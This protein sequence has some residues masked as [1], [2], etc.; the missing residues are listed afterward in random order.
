MIGQRAVRHFI[1]QFALLASSLTI[2]G[3]C[4]P[5][6][7]LAQI[8]PDQTL[9]TETTQVSPNV[10]VEDLPA[11]LIEGGAVRG[12]TLFHSFQNFNVAEF[13]RVYFAN[14]NGIET[15]LSRV[16]GRNASTILGTLGV[17]GA[18]D[19]FLLNPNGIVF[20]PNAQL[21]VAGSFL[22]STADRFVLGENQAFSAVDPNAPP[23]L[24]VN[25]TPGL[26][27]SAT[28]QGMIQNQ[29]QLQV[30]AGQTLTLLGD[31]VSHRGGLNAPQGTVEI[32]GNYVSLEDQAQV[33]TSGES[34]GGTVRIGGAFQGQGTVPTALRTY[35]GPDVQIRSD[36]I[37][38]G[39]G[40]NVTVWAN[41]ITGFYGQISAQGAELGQGGQVEVSGHQ[42]L[43]FRGTVNTA[44]VNGQMGT[45]L[46][47][48]TDI[49]IASGAGDSG[50]DGTNTF[51]GN[52]SATPGAILSTPLSAVNDTAPTTIFE[53]E[54]ETLAG[55]TNVILQ[56]TNNI[57]I[58][59]LADNALTF[60]VGNGT[61]Q[62][63]ADADQSGAGSVFVSDLNDRIVTNG[64]DFSASGASITL[65][66]INT[67]R[68]GSSGGDITLNATGSIQTRSL[69]TASQNAPGDG[70][71]GDIIFSAGTDITVSD[72]FTG[73]GNY[74]LIQTRSQNANGNGSGGDVTFNAGRDVNVSATA[75]VNGNDA[76]E[77]ELT[78]HLF[79]TSANNTGG[80]SLG[81]DIS[82]SAGRDVNVALNATV[83]AVEDD[84]TGED[85]EISSDIR[86]FNT[87]ANN[88][89]TSGNSIG[90]DITLS[91]DRQ[92][93]L[94][95]EN[96]VTTDIQG[97]T[98]DEVEIDADMTWGFRTDARGGDDG[99]TIGDVQG[100]DVQFTAGDDVNL[101][102][103][104]VAE[105]RF[106]GVEIE[107]E[108]IDI[109]P[110]IGDVGSTRALIET[111]AQN[112]TDDST[113]GNSIGGTVTFNPGG[114][115]NLTIHHDAITT[116]T[117]GSVLNTEDGFSASVEAQ[118]INTSARG[119][120]GNST[121]QDV[122]AGDIVLTPGGD[123]NLAHRSR[124]ITTVSDAEMIR[125]NRDDDFEVSLE[126][127]GLDASAIG[128]DDDS[129]NQTITGGRITL[130]PDGNLNVDIT[131]I[132]NQSLN[133]SDANSRIDDFDVESTIKNA[134]NASA[135][136]PDGDD[137]TS[138]AVQGGTIQIQPGNN[139][140]F[141][142]RQNI[143][144]TLNNI[145]ITD[146]FEVDPDVDNLFNVSA[147]ERDDDSSASAVRGGQIR[148]N[149]VNDLNINIL[150]AVTNNVANAILDNEIEVDFDSSIMNASGRGAGGDGEGSD[151]Q[152]GEI[153]LNVAGD[154]TV[155]GRY[156]SNFNG[157]PINEFEIEA[158]HTALST[159]STRSDRR[160]LGGDITLNVGGDVVIDPNINVIRLDG[161]NVTNDEQVDFSADDGDVIAL[162]TSADENRRSTGSRDNR[163]PI[164]LD[165]T[166]GDIR[167][168]AGGA[169]YIGSRVRTLADENGGGSIAGDI[170]FNA[171]GDI[172][173]LRDI[174]AD[175]ED[176]DGIGEA[177]NVR[178][179]SGG[180]I[181]TGDII[182]RTQETFDRG[183][184]GSVFLQAEG[185]IQTGDIETYS[186]L[187]VSQ[188]E[189]ILEG[190]GGDI[191]LRSRN[192]SVILDG[193]NVWADAL[194]NG[195]GG[196]I[197]FEGNAVR[198]T[199]G[200]E[201]RTTAAGQGESGSITIDAEGQILLN[202][203][204]LFTF[205]DLSATADGGDILLSAD[206]VTLSNFS[207]IDTATFGTGDA[208]DVE[209]TA[210]RIELNGD[211]LNGGRNPNRG[212]SIFSITAGEGDAGRIALNA[213][214]TGTVALRDRSSI[215][216]A[217]NATSTGDGNTITIETGSL[218]L[219][220]GS[221][222]TAL[223]RGQ[224]VAGDV[225]VMAAD[226]VEIS[227]IGTGNYRSG[228][229]TSSNEL[230]SGA[231]GDI[232]VQADAMR[233]MDG[234]VLSA[235][236]L[237]QADGGD[238][239]VDV[240]RLELHNGGQL[241]TST[242]GA[243]DAGDI[244]VNAAEDIIIT[245][246][247]SAVLGTPDLPPRSDVA[248]NDTPAIALD[249]GEGNN[250]DF[251]NA[252]FL[253]DDSFSLDG[254]QTN[255]NIEL[256]NRIPYASI[257][258]SLSNPDDNSQPADVDFYRFEVTAGTRAIFDID[259]GKRNEDF[260]IEVALF[261]PARNELFS[262][263]RNDDNPFYL[264]GE[265]SIPVGNPN[266]PSDSI[267]PYRRFVFTEPG[268]YYFS[269]SVG[270]DADDFDN[271]NYQ[272]NISLDTP[273]VVGNVATDNIASGLFVQTTGAGD[274]G[275]VA[276]NTARLAINNGG[277]I[278]AS[279]E[280]LG[281]GGSINIEADEAISIRNNSQ[282]SVQAS[283]GGQAGG[284][285]L[286][287]PQLSLSNQSQVTAIA[288]AT[289]TAT[290][291]GDITVNAAQI[292]LQGNRTNI[293]AATQ[294]RVPAGT[295]TVRP[296]PNHLNI[297]LA[298]GASISASTSG[299]G[300]GGIL[301]VTAPEAITI[302]G[303]GQLAASASGAG[304]AGGVLLDT[305]RLTIRDGVNITAST[306]GAGEGGSLTVIAPEAITIRNNSQLEASTSGV[307]DA[308]DV[309]LNTQ[310]L[311]LFN[312]SNVS[313][314][315]SGTGIG[316]S[317]TVI[318]P[319]SVNL[320]QQ[321]SLS[322]EATATGGVAGSLDITTGEMRVSNGSTV[323]VS[324]ED[325][326][327]GNLNVTANRLFLN[328][329][330]LTA[331]TGQ[332]GANIFLDGLEYIFMENESLISAT[333]FG[334]ANGGNITIFADFIIAT[335]PTGRF[336]SDIIAN[337]ER[338][339]GG[340]IE[341]TTNGLF[342]IEFRDELT[343]D[344]DIT[345]SSEFGLSG[346]FIQNDLGIDPS[347]GLTDLPLNLT[348]PAGLIDRRCNVASADQASEFVVTGR[349]GLP[350]APN[351]R[352]DSDIV[353][354]DLGPSEPE[355]QAM[356]SSSTQ[357]NQLTG[358]VP[359]VIVEPQQWVVDEQGRLQLVASVTD[360]NHVEGAIAV[361]GVCGVNGE[362]GL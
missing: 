114:D 34:G 88:P 120:N 218:S 30:G 251:D 285:T 121:G 90:G 357:N 332:G 124:A 171:G 334:D 274:A 157:I 359:E 19:L 261:D 93:N 50:A 181:A 17:T 314:S 131:H 119:A 264:G 289:N 63:T 213:G 234:G 1:V 293:T 258:G 296:N 254:D 325:G 158:E 354:D 232:A 79:D 48:P 132:A 104:N 281:E 150:T 263:N 204:R 344:N 214:P 35:I 15:I 257:T 4:R 178:L 16:T 216:T 42:H 54:L 151:I 44:A 206:R 350:P 36:A 47:D 94:Q 126:T 41:E 31:T 75:T 351:E 327:A 107:G 146:D 170:T 81:G 29:A 355:S 297:N 341:I 245:G 21:D 99:L 330:S 160:S 271:L 338:G 197:E 80:D 65:G 288:T 177:G 33:D 112:A 52:V 9:G 82:L 28:Q 86:P 13:Q 290:A 336:G 273:N 335:N 134:F 152:G 2:S 339:T 260:D 49:T 262:I 129:T 45:L 210:N 163:R 227:G 148:A 22:A 38:T 304:D 173:L 70:N 242:S 320:D 313:A 312:D 195:D 182:A 267:D 27:Y 308:G 161:V 196:D 18:A 220:G 116:F 193:V 85:I 202:S 226:S 348:D 199:N 353:L 190:N 105:T 122:Q 225:D 91:A 352:I 108:Q 51:A 156:F 319:E 5:A 110:D 118:L 26:Q 189:T 276:L 143:T 106:D 184:G 40:G 61:I 244:N 123:L 188:D 11:E 343:P 349:G 243:G 55:N 356:P 240:R 298:D 337:A 167:I 169:I 83:N 72:N 128:P 201:V 20:G 172:T 317:L 73:E 23:L 165:G 3:L 269:V 279:T 97:G 361:E 283:G 74:T 300:E 231:G 96:R 60:A 71:G 142:I 140:N 8:V 329:G 235:Q 295:L 180:N 311:S 66:R 236:T 278:L 294:G 198:L 345:V 125:N 266:T 59:D 95:F 149:Q 133:P 328:A 191:T 162:S 280:S 250:N 212:S 58:A 78:T 326:I 7:S 183:T 144:N 136:G 316:G 43:I 203:S 153:N 192:G 155:R 89:G 77:I 115:A 248:V 255:P 360:A 154:L 139:A 321:S 159:E 147:R 135:A 174:R 12:S 176:T 208:G 37:A 340:R 277:Q 127:R 241:I 299:A 270:D 6:P 230:D 306:S 247:N 322:V 215:S 207:S 301:T 117:G 32:L 315:T 68:N 64:R 87:S 109:G 259:T 228:I 272:L 358:A 209:I 246:S 111:S 309:E 46:L 200:T 324:S 10:T 62:L 265:G 103:N 166:S 291:G 268:V 305:Q 342:G 24:T 175:A 222:L 284:V 238:I 100:G 286:T 205:V 307:G 347:R 98:V 282:V 57:A 130:A 185:N 164:S 233:L 229:F 217:V 137:S 252:I 138:G 141:N 292:N 186:I 145:E 102:V 287:T 187:D 224:G 221:Q 101:N 219:T 239:E 194:G 323:T 56:A 302:Q 253:N 39:N 331:E 211:G 275:G 168:D 25:V 113:S 362:E 310:R 318:A 223:T 76:E 92:L 67:S 333:A 249:E 346:T 237:G 53:S 84:N 256:S 179:V 14:P 69:Q 303:D